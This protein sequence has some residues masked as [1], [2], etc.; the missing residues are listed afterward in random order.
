M[1]DLFRSL[2]ALLTQL[3]DDDSVREAV[4]FA[5][6]RRAAGELLLEH[7]SQ[8]NV[9]DKRLVIAVSSKA[10]QRNLEDLSGQMIFKINSLLGSAIV[11][12]IEFRV[13]ETLVR[14]AARCY[15]TSDETD[16]FESMAMAEITP[17][18]IA[19][20]AAIGDDE[21]RKHFLLAA[22]TCLNRKK[23]LAATSAG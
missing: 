6:W 10:W 4:V 19:S 9:I 20:A 1:D 14:K 8:V 17:N 7:T 15:G 16:K 3:D 12:Y 11:T 21:M 22:G 2:P 5:A 23:R 18:L 13:D